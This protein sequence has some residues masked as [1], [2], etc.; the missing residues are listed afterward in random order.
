MYI[1][2]GDPSP[3]QRSNKD[4]IYSLYL[5]HNPRRKTHDE[6]TDEIHPPHAA[7][8]PGR[9]LL[10]LPLLPETHAPA[11]GRHRVAAHPAR[12]RT[13][14]PAEGSFTVTFLAEGNRLA[15]VGDC[16]RLAAT[17]STDESRTL[18][19]GPVAATRMACPEGSDEKAFV[20]ALEATTHY[21]MDGPLLL[22][23]ADGELRAV[24][25]ALPAAPAQ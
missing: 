22:L 25:Q 18:H 9:K 3:E 16:N 7:C 6:T 4:T 23:L 21:D 17:Y 8:G 13:I 19:I 15:G 11:A 1:P 5:Q 14:R 24:L 10:P 12:R 2:F 20:E